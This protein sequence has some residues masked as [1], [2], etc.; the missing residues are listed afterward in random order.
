MNPEIRFRVPKHV[1]GLA[2]ERAQSLGLQ[3]RRGRTGGASELARGALYAFL[4]LGLPDDL[5][6]RVS[7]DFQKVRLQA[8]SASDSFHRIT[9][10]HRVSEEYRKR[11]ALKEGLKISARQT[12]VFEFAQGDLPHF[13]V[14]YISL[15][16]DGSPLAVLNLEGKLS[17]RPNSLFELTA[18]CERATL[19]E[20]EN[21]LAELERRKEQRLL[22]I[23]R[24][25][26][27]RARGEKIL[28]A[29]AEEAGSELLKARLNG[30]FD[31]L[32]LAAHEHARHHLEKLGLVEIE[33]MPTTQALEAR[34]FRFENVRPQSKPQ[35][36]SIQE[37]NRILQLTDAGLTA[38]IVL[39]DDQD[40]S[41]QEGI[42]VKFRS[43]LG[44][45]L[46]FL[47][48]LIPVP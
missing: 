38:E 31:W 20:L 1:L 3:T 4:G 40:G 18:E 29:W 21:C 25:K 5:Q 22:E 7:P 35:L 48:D 45:S 6:N 19:K 2:Q 13:L 42:L 44:P 28:A 34:E 10:H 43:P 15:A 11:S 9:V 16:A 37:L 27:Q 32:E 36:P 41:T 14:P 46:H 33:F 17:P 30:N 24:R 12:T 26:N 39:V 23:E 8:D 47:H